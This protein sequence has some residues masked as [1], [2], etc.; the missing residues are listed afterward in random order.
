MKLTKQRD[1]SDCS[2]AALDM[3]LQFHGIRV[4]YSEICQNIGI[5]K[6]GGTLYGVCQTGQQ[7]GLDADALSGS[8]EEFRKAVLD[9]EISLPCIA[10]IVNREQFAHFV[11]VS[12]I[13]DEKV[14]ICDPDPVVGK[15]TLS[16]QDFAS[17]F[18]GEVVAFRKKADFRRI[19]RKK[20]PLVGIF[21]YALQNRGTIAAVSVISMLV[22]AVGLGSSFLLRYIV[23]GILPMGPEEA[24]EELDIFA[25]LITFFGIFYLVRFGLQQ[26]KGFLTARLACR[27]NQKLTQDVYQKLIDLPLGFFTT[28]E[29]GDILSRFSD[30]NKINST[31]LSSVLSVF[32]D[33]TMLI[34]SGAVILSTSKDIFM[35]AVTVMIIYLVVSTAFIKTLDRSNKDVLGENAALYSHMKET[36]DGITTVKACGAEN[37]AK[38]KFNGIFNALQSSLM[39][40]SMKSISKQNLIELISG[41]GNLAILWIGAYTAVSGTFSSGSLV[42]VLTL[43]SYFFAPVESFI[44][45][46]SQIQEA[47]AAAERLEDITIA[48]TVPDKTSGAVMQD[49]SIQF[50]HVTFG[51]RNHTP[52]LEN[53]SFAIPSGSAAALSGNSGS[54]KTTAAKIIAGFYH[55]ENGKI[56]LGGCS[57]ETLSDA[58]I[59]RKICYI[60]Q[61]SFL[62]TASIRD[63]LLFGNDADISD[64]EMLDTLHTCCADFVS[65]LPQGLDTILAENGSTLSFGQRQKLSIARAILRKPAVMILDESTSNLDHASAMEIIQRINAM[66][67]MTK[68][69]ISHDAAILDHCERIYTIH[70]GKMI[71]GCRKA[72]A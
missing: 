8:A 68:I 69:W 44:S 58:E 67:D 51:Y 57:P 53:I 37:Q 54:G 34:A 6:Q 40:L 43:L 16:A 32:L 18:L 30:A 12:K 66:P 10:R 4:P 45:L 24:M 39:K 9:G 71:S 3:I 56:L 31:V 48:Q 59:H 17:I 28:R 5:D 21:R 63:N 27:M 23:D 50:E 41:I 47:H 14:H 15:Y 29:T 25:V 33:L 2:A 13:T 38:D 60:P 42:L 22:T 11:V 72:A 52:I 20:D 70:Q 26:L 55:A 19:R 7:Y 35:A 61:E 64:A 65:Q 46:Q 62:F 49:G 36:I 1:Q